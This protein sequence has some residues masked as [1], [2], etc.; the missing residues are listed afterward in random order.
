M[1][2][3]R[4][5][6]SQWK[7]SRPQAHLAEHLAE[8][9]DLDHVADSGRRA[10]ALDVCRLVRSQPGV[11]PGSRDCE[12][13]PHR[14]G[15]GDSLAFAIAGSPEATDDGVDVVSVAFCV[16]QSFQEE[17]CGPFTHDE[18]VGACVI[19]PRAARRERAD[20]AELDEAGNAHV[21]VDAAC[22]NCV[23]V[24]LLEA[25]DR[26]V[27]GRECRGTGCI[28]HEV[29]TVE[30]EE[31]GDPAGDDVAELAR[32]GVFRDIREAPA[33]AYVQLVENRVS[34]VGAQR[35]ERRRPGEFLGVFREVGA[36]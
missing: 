28:D 33:N 2:D 36:Q 7:C 32:H 22:E 9:V 30:V 31:V 34:G 19:R 35:L 24:A 5:H 4:F 11:L 27:D 10:V 1:P 15:G 23:V 21:G 14:I 16:G 6:R 3:V 13:L 26:C 12:L 25:F 20:L 8:A 17:H 29:R 18:A